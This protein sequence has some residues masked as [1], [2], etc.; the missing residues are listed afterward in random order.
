MRKIHLVGLALVAVFSFCA[1]AA[2]SVF[3]A[4]EWLIDEA[5]VSAQTALGRI[6]TEGELLLWDM[7]TNGAVL[8]SG[9]AEGTIGPGAKDVTDEILDLNGEK[10]E[11]LDCPID[12]EVAGNPCE[13]STPLILVLPLNLPW[14]TEV[15]LNAAGMFVDDVTGTGGN[16]GYEVQNCLVFGLPVKDVCTGPAEVLLENIDRKSVV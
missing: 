8:C 13:S 14:N 12:T 6:M 9:L 7:G 16:P 5:P 2:P 15:L 10:L 4:D 11:T 1:I 3:A